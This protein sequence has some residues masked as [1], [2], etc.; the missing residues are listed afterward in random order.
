MATD[1][2]ALGLRSTTA[3]TAAKATTTGTKTTLDQSDFLALMT[4]Q[5]KNQDPFN[6]V[7]NTQMVAQMA[8][9]SSTAGISQMNATLSG[10]AT[11]L[12]ATSASDAMA[13]VGKTVLTEGSTAYERTSGGI[14]GAVELDA[15]ASDVQV[16]IA[17][18]DG[19]VV[20]TMQLGSQAAGTATY[21]W[22][23]K[24]DAGN[25]VEAGP[26]TVSVA[27][28]D[29][30]STVAARGLVWAPVESASLPSGGDPTLKVTG[31][32]TVKPSAIRSVA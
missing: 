12:G 17:D 20:K 19:R 26:Y 18:S 31:I 2:A 25:A 21:D 10:I 3:A 30:S 1:Y 24:D 14:A 9:F 27:A 16:S 4:A 32:G 8:Q 28:A 15:K 13:Y 23:G 22:D 6:P 11:K 5:M 7:D 29:G